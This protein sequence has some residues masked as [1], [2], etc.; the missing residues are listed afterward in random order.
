[1]TLVDDYGDRPEAGQ[2]FITMVTRNGDYF[3]LVIDRDDKGNENV[4]FLNQVDEADILQLMDEEEA[5]KYTEPAGVDRPVETEPAPSQET[6]QKA[7]DFGSEEPGKP[8]R[9]RFS[10]LPVVVILLLMA[11]IGGAYIFVNRKGSK[12]LTGRK[13]MERNRS[14]PKDDEDEYDFEEEAYENSFTD[15]DV[16]DPENSDGEYFYDGDSQNEEDIPEGEYPVGE[17]DTPL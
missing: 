3:Y 5:A 2:Q 15:M 14:C 11:G 4:H 1:M 7:D 16:D 10:L 9:D 13:G 17:S 8:G 12:P 6:G